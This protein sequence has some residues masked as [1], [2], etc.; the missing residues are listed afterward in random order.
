V[1]ATQEAPAYHPSHRWDVVSPRRE[2]PGEQADQRTWEVVG[3]FHNLHTMDF[4]WMKSSKEK[5]NNV[6]SRNI[7][8]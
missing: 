7:N 6:Y 1:P 8:A 4:V 2:S 3:S 5:L